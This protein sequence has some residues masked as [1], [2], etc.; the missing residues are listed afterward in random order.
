MVLFFGNNFRIANAVT[1]FPLP[2]SPTIPRISFSNTSKLML[3][4]ALTICLLDK[5]LILKFF[6]EISGLDKGSFKI[7]YLLNYLVSFINVCVKVF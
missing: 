7:N 6:I 1:D 4:T 3:L 5:K 2:D